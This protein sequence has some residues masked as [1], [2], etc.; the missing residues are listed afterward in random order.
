[1]DRL[2]I[3]FNSASCR[4]YKWNWS[5]NLARWIMRLIDRG[6]KL[7]DFIFCIGELRNMKFFFNSVKV[8]I[9]R[10]AWPNVNTGG[11]PRALKEVA[12]ESRHAHCINYS[13]V[14]CFRE[15]D[16]NVLHQKDECG[17]HA[18]KNADRRLYRCTNW[19]NRSAR[20]GPKPCVRK[21]THTSDFLIKI[22]AG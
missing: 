14:V 19:F 9:V 10:I 22:A 13:N 18:Q 17:K 12:P 20:L 21:R 11:W 16:L 2:C 8:G 4:R 3:K 15:F 7:L 1:M 5:L 6:W